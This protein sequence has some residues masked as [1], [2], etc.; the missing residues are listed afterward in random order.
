MTGGSDL[1]ERRVASVTPPLARV[2]ETNAEV[3]RENIETRTTQRQL[4]VSNTLPIHDQFTR[5]GD[6]LR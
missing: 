4:V 6:R 1:S 2:N 5:D 3:L